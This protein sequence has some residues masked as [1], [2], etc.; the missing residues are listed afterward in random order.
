MWIWL[1][2]GLALFC[3][4]LLFCGRAWWEQVLWGLLTAVFVAQVVM[5]V[6]AG[7]AAV[8]EDETQSGG[9]LLRWKARL[10]S[11]VGP[12][13]GGTV[14]GGYLVGGWIGRGGGRYGAGAA[15]SKIEGS[16]IAKSPP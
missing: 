6:R 12:S 14:R 2:A 15:L 13:G 16:N 11:A 4:G 9:R 3:L 8:D 1:N 5:A 7:P 10:D